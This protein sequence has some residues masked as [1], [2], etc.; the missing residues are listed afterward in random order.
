MF[1]EGLQT[2]EE[3]ELIAALRGEFD[4]AGVYTCALRVREVC[5]CCCAAR[6]VLNKLNLINLC[7]WDVCVGCV[8]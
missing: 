8:K 3:E 6:H 5:C 4:D 7:A 1:R 2:V